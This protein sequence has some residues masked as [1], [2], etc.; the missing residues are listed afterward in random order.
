MNDSKGVAHQSLLLRRVFQNGLRDNKRNHP[1]PEGGQTSPALMNRS[2]LTPS[3]KDGSGDN[4]RNRFQEGFS[5]GV[6][7]T[8]AG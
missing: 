7:G 5:L 3:P 8:L 1:P 2:E 6:R 4:L